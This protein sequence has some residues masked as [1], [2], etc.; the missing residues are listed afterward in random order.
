MFEGADLR[1]A[2]VFHAVARAGGIAAAARTIGDGTVIA[3]GP[4]P[5]PMP[6][7]AGVLRGQI[8]IEA[9]ERA[10]LQAFLSRWLDTLREMPE[11]K[12]VR[13]SIDVDPVDLY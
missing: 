12:A 2:A 3:H 10:T 7:R 8:L 11:G 13:W 9:A 6:R 5:A 4:M 1:R